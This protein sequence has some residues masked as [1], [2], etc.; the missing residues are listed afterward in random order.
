MSGNGD[1]V[2]VVKKGHTHKFTL[3]EV[4]G[5]TLLGDVTLKVGV[6]VD[7]KKHETVKL[8]ATTPKKPRG[9]PRNIRDTDQIA[10][11]KLGENLPGLSPVSISPGA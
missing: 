4:D 7:K 6:D 9:G 5:R 1:S 10:R 11:K 2:A 3:H 8:M